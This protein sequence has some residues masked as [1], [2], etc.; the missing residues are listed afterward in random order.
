M[1]VATRLPNSGLILYDNPCTVSL[2]ICVLSI[3]PRI[4]LK[5][6]HLMILCHAAEAVS[7]HLSMYNVAGYVCLT[8]VG[9]F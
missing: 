2:C 7:L 8:M 3:G 1:H 6:I 9:T 4:P 5:P